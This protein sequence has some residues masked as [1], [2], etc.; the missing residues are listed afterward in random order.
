MQ[1]GGRDATRSLRKHQLSVS[2]CLSCSGIFC[3]TTRQG[4]LTLTGGMEGL[5]ASPSVQA[6]PEHVFFKDQP[7]VASKSECR[8]CRR[9][10][11]SLLL[12]WLRDVINKKYCLTRCPVECRR[13]GVAAALRVHSRTGLIQNILVLPPTLPRLTMC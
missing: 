5:S 4:T 8:S 11:Y 12:T 9:E 2:P 7:A 3:C 10:E 13:R 1:E 6:P